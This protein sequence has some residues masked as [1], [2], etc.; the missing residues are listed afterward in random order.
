MTSRP[1]FFWF[2]GA[3]IIGMFFVSVIL[4]YIILFFDFVLVS[5]WGTFESSDFKLFVLFPFVFLFF[6]I[7]SHPIWNYL[8]ECSRYVVVENG[9]VLFNQKRNYSLKLS[10]MESFF[11]R[12]YQYAL[13]TDRN[14]PFEFQFKK[15]KKAPEWQKLR[16]IIN[17][18]RRESNQK[19][20]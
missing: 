3:L 1:R 15:M 2:S 14:E 17:K 9:M 13:S 12:E 19:E 7:F 8:Y 11:I 18:D 6:V 4:I 10:D 16:D 5:L 20:L